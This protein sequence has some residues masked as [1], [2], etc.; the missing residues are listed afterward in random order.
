L[1]NRIFDRLLDLNWFEREDDK[2]TVYRLTETGITELK[3][4]GVDI[5]SER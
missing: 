3:K 2:A 1:G 5:Y 4:L